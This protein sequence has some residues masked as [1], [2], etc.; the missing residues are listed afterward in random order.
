LVVFAGGCGAGQTDLM[1]LQVGKSWTYHV[2]SGLDSRVE[3]VKVVRPVAVDGV[4]GMELNGPLGISRL[5]WRHNS[6]LAESTSDLRFTPALPLLSANGTGAP[7]TG[8]VT[9][10]G[11]DIAA[12]AEVTQK[13]R[14]LP[15]NSRTIDS[16]ESDVVLRLPS[17]SIRLTTWFEP[18]VGIVRQEQH[19]GVKLDI[20]LELIEGP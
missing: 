11:R 1:P 16:I 2:M 10:M 9:W 19:T 8:W 18:G 20:G 7:W 14:T 4:E 15:L 6:L 5:A 12:T 13:P 3:S 17:R